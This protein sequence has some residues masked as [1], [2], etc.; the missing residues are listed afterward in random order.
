MMQRFTEG[1]QQVLAI[2]QEKASEFGHDYIGTEHILLGLL[3]QTDGVASKALISLGLTEKEVE[4]IYQTAIKK[5]N[6]EILKRE[7][8]DL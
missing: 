3:G 4:K 6:Q 1:A 7:L 2:A 8:V 5:L